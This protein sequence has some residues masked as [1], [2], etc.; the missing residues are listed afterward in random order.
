MY[1]YSLSVHSVGR[2]NYVGCGVVF[3]NLFF[4]FGFEFRNSGILG[5]LSFEFRN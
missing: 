3:K 4:E 1:I 2:L 5:Q